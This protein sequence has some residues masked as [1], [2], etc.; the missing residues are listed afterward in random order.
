MDVE[1]RFM[2]DGHDR[3][4]SRWT[5]QPVAMYRNVEAGNLQFRVMARVGRQLMPE[6]ATLHLTVR[7]PWFWTWWSRLAYLLFMA[8]PVYQIVRFQR[9]RNQLV[10][11]EKE[12]EVNER[13][14]LANEQLRAANE[15]L[16]LANKMKDE[17]LASASHELRTPLTAILG[18]TSVLKEEVP[19]ENMEFLS[20][21]DEN[22][23]RLLQTINSLLDLAKLRAGMLELNFSRIDVGEKVEE[24]VDLLTQLAKNQ[25][26]YLEVHRPSEHVMARLDDHCFERILY[27]LIG[28]AIKF[29]QYGGVSVIA[30][31][32]SKYVLVHVKDTGIG[33]DENFIPMLFDEFKQEPANHMRV[34]GSGL[35]LTITAELVELMDGAITVESKKGVGSTF[36]VSFP[37][38][39]V[40]W[41]RGEQVTDTESEVPSHSALP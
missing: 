9:A 19:P 32:T 28:N 31:R 3:G 8:L 24:V 29:T 38:A 34:E 15:H 12:R 7:P 5:S 30:E 23:K 20:L 26:L 33:I 2:L 6:V 18:F 37:I 27:N 39:D 14:N 35:G 11:L 16:E 13:L 41:P 22:G 21:I 36:T 4:W 25:G 40:T 10:E 17:F 1:Y